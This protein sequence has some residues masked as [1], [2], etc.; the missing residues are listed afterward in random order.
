[1][2]WRAWFCLLHPTASSAT[3]V[4]AKQSSQTK[5][6]ISFLAWI[7]LQWEGWWEMVEL[8]WTRFFPC[9][10]EFGAQCGKCVPHGPG[11][12]QTCYEQIVTQWS[13]LV[14]SVWILN[15]VCHHPRPNT[16]PSLQFKMVYTQRWQQP[17]HSFILFID[18][19][20]QN[21]AV[22]PQVWM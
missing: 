8:G 22:V 12:Q 2:G 14:W 1:M 21:F 13:L 4:C 19:I 20:K 10:P 11:L 7:L 15:L 3:T 9:S 16:E 17:Y 18:K 5:S 6:C